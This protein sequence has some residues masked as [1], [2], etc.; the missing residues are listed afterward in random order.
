MNKM[1]EIEIEK[2]F[3]KYIKDFHNVSLVLKSPMSNDPEADSF[4]IRIVLEAYRFL[5]K[6]FGAKNIYSNNIYELYKQ[7]ALT[8]IQGVIL[9][10]KQDYQQGELKHFEKSESDMNINKKLYV[11]VDRIKG[12]NKCEF[13][14]SRLIR[15]CEELNIAYQNKC[16]MSVAMIVRSIIDHIPPLFGFDTFNEVA[17][18]Y[19][20]TKS[21]KDVA[22]SLN[23]TLRKIADSHLHTPIRKK[24]ILPTD[25][26]VDFKQSLDVL[27][28]EIIRINI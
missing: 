27:L 12:I 2:E 25:I 4:I 9:A 26:Q 17:N 6:L 23:D 20:G 7:G 19:R 1:S 13:D 16:Y 22:K 18:N 28:T 5:Q 14:L 11:S 3:E 24:E 21:F 15:L 8:S 10:A